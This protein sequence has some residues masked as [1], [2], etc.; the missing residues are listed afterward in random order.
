MDVSAIEVKYYYYY[1]AQQI[2]L[3]ILASQN[4]SFLLSIFWLIVDTLLFTLGQM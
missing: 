2:S 4:T 3:D 1:K